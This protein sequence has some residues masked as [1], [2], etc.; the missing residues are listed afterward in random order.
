[1]LKLIPINKTVWV[2]EFQ[3]CFLNIMSCIQMKYLGRAKSSYESNTVKDRM[4]QCRQILAFSINKD[5]HND[6]N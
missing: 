2:G 4:K 1:M 5:I 6:D 3:G